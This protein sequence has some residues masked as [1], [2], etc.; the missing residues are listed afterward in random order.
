MEVLAIML[1]RKKMGINSLLITQATV[2][3]FDWHNARLSVD[4]KLNQLADGD[5]LAAEDHNGIVNSSHSFI[6][7]LDVK[8]N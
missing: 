8:M 7:K 1:I 4:F 6:K 3:P 2:T 5:N